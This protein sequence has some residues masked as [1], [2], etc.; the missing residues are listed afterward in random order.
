MAKIESFR[1]WCQKVLPLV[2]DES[3]SYYE[4]LCKMTTYLNNTIQAVNENTEDTAQMRTEITQFENFINN[5]FDNLD[6]QE[7]INNKLDSMAES[8]ELT[9]LMKPYIDSLFDDISTQ[10]NTIET[11]VNLANKRIDNIIALPDGSTTAD[12]ELID[13]RT[14]SNGITYPSAGAAVRTQVSELYDHGVFC[15]MDSDFISN[16]SNLFINKSYGSD[17]SGYVIVGDSTNRALT[18]YAMMLKEDTYI[19]P[20]DS[21]YRMNIITFNT[22]NWL[23]SVR[24]QSETGV[25]QASSSSPKIIPKNTWFILVAFKVD[26]TDIL[27]SE[28]PDHYRSEKAGRDIDG[29]LDFNFNTHTHSIY[30]HENG[31]ISDNDSYNVIRLQPIPIKAG[32]T[33]YYRNIYAY[34][35]GVLTNSGWTSLSSNTGEHIGGYFTAAAD[36]LLCVSVHNSSL[37]TYAVFGEGDGRNFMLAKDA[38]AEFQNLK[39]AVTEA[40]KHFE[41]VVRVEAGTYNLIEEYGADF[42]TVAGSGL[43]LKNRIK[44]IF[45]ALSRVVCNYTGS[46][47]NIR[48]D[49]SPFNSGLYGFTLDG[50]NLECSNVRYCIHDERSTTL[51]AYTNIYHNCDLYLDNSANTDGYKQCVGGGLG[52]NGSIEIDNCRF[53][54]EGTVNF[55]LVSWHNNLSAN[56]K[57]KIVIKDCYFEGS[58]SIRFSWYGSS[59]LISEM[60][61][62]NNSIGRAILV[63]AETDTSASSIENVKLYQWNNELRNQ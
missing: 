8:G 29:C 36:G 58:N 44:L 22:D 51:D 48:H 1:F 11:N 45:S 9:N 30:V 14:S 59:T 10:V 49:F 4:L 12:A 24:A 41:C 38:L 16:C 54:S 18:P 57:S 56:S 23:G 55:E 17:P 7:E 26:N 50:L 60:Y 37:A 35:S 42:E 53:K 47:Y 46:N 63:R 19:V 6:V 21:N 5:Y 52:K 28:I 31:S 13:I 20:T 39:D 43:L 34:F 40:T 15:Q 27:P 2:Y 61:A 25:I 62:S 33:Y 3:L 32:R